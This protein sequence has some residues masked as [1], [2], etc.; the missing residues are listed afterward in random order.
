[1]SKNTD[2]I[3]MCLEIPKDLYKKLNIAIINKH[4]KVYGHIKE[5]IVEGIKLWLEKEK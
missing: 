4:G 1:M 3:K 2:R 5:S